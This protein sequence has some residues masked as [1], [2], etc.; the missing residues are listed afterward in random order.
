MAESSLVPRV[1]LVFSFLA[2]AGAAVAVAGTSRTRP[3]S[4][5][6]LAPIAD[7]DELERRMTTLERQVELMR[8]GVAV[9]SVA[10]AKGA[11]AAAPAAGGPPAGMAELDQRVVQL[12]RLAA[13]ITQG[14]QGARPLSPEAM[15]A[16]LRTVLDRQLSVDERAAALTLLRPNEGRADGRTHDVVVAALELLE[17]PDVSPRT[18]AG[19]IRDLDHL[20]DPTL[21]DP[22]VGILSRD[23]DGRTRREAV[24]TLAVFYDDPQVRGLVERL[25][26]SDPDSQV[27]AQAIKQLGRWQ[28]RTGQ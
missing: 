12:E 25:R 1:S 27:R 10:Q 15:A 7:I 8:V 17:K 24:E 5:E 11:P 22:L 26:D 23:A 9:R 4:S 14:R 16:A 19:M 21:K 28:A 6:P 3:R 20:K 13:E 2:L 18:R